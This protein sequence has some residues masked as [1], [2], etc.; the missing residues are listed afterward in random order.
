MLNKFCFESIA[1]V[2]WVILALNVVMLLG[3]I[4]PSSSMINFVLLYSTIL[5]V[6]INLPI[7][8]LIML[9]LIIH[10]TI[11]G[12]LKNII[13]LMVRVLLVVFTYMLIAK[14]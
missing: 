12:V 10:R 13:L 4:H 11:D 6:L 2:T 9:N 14:S 5:I 7:L 3:G 1:G 8:I